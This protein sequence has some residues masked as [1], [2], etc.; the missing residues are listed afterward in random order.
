MNRGDTL[1]GPLYEIR[2][3]GTRAAAI[4][5]IMTTG[6]LGWLGW[7]PLEPVH[8]GGLGIGPDQDLRKVESNAL[9][10]VFEDAT[11]QVSGFVHATNGGD[12][13]T[14]VAWFDYNNDGWL[15]FYVANGIGHDDGLMRNNGDGTFTNVIDQAG[16]GDANGSSG[17]VTGDLDND[18]HS[19]LIVVGEPG[20]LV[21]FVV[22]SPKSI[23]VFKNNGDGTFTD[24]TAGS[25]IEIPNEAGM[26][27]QP[28]LGDI[29]NDGLVDVFVTG[30]GSVNTQQLKPSHMFRNLGGF[31]FTDIS[32]VSGTDAAVGACPAAF[33]H[34][35]D[36][37]FIDL[38]IADCADILGRPQAM[39][40]L[41]NNGDLTFT[42]I[43]GQVNL[44]DSDLN[45][46][47]LGERGFWMCVALGD[48]DNDRDFDLF[49]TN[50]GLLFD[51]SL[52]PFFANQPHGFFERGTDGKFISVEQ[53]VGIDPLAEHF[54]WGGSFADFNNDGWE[55]LVFVGN[56]PQPPFLQ[57]GNP[58]YLFVNQGDKTFRRDP[59]PVDLGNRFSTGLAV[60]DYNNDGAVDVVV[61]NGAYAGD[62]NPVP[63]LLKNTPPKNNRN[64]WI[65]VR[66]VGTESNRDAIGSRVRVHLPGR[67]LTKEIRAGSSFL[68]QDSLWL[69]FGLNK[70]RKADKIEVF[71]P[72]GKVETFVKVNG[73]RMVT[74]T[75][76]QGVR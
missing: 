24:V 8:A 54:S 34:Y 12:A 16:F 43:T 23:R 21:L 37:G 22:P 44:P 10:V 13:G 53:Q 66:L 70:D 47:Q 3:L 68:S 2:R 63:V 39:R 46:P 45:N 73:Q 17:V 62:P 33:S 71:W 42:D 55:D 26:A 60:A 25:G 57:V 11:D 30:P 48:Y 64:G 18:G 4:A 38:Y 72:S 29:D 50:L 6:W 56:I 74:I 35:D 28:V 59:L 14:G 15:D 65:T 69:T 76:G 5:A 32:A 36:D 61:S 31:K 19:D 20:A 52:I 75:E 51:G 40:L 58:G 67:V 41:K 7:P 1:V 49:A 27:L 9:P